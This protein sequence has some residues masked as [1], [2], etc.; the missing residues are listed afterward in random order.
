MKSIKHRLVKSV[1]QLKHKLKPISTPRKFLHQNVPYFSQWESRE[2]N[3]QILGKT[4]LAEDDP[5]WRNSGA[6]TKEEYADW[7]WAGCGMACTKMLLAHHTG[8]AIPLVKLGE[9][10]HHYG[11]YK[12]P[13]LTS[14][15]LHYAPYAKFMQA[16]F[17]LRARPTVPLLL[18]EVIAELAK[19]NYILASVS[20]QIRHPEETPARKGGHL[21]LVLGYDLDREVMIFHN[22]SGDSKKSQEYAEI[23]FTDFKKF[24]AEKGIIVEPS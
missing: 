5:K 9:K 22:P 14:T 19:G 8:K 24:F 18:N 7:S 1:K 6:K 15:G 11:G 4:M 20:P 13:L 2:L 21:I 16:E 17:G 10:C 23:P 3:K 12:T